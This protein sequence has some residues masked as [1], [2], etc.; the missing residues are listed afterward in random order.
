M[1]GA[2]EIMQR[3]V[4]FQR[5]HRLHHLRGRQPQI[6][7]RH[8]TG[9]AHSLFQTV[10][11]AQTAAH[12]PRHRPAALG[13]TV[14]S[15][16]MKPDLQIDAA[17]GFHGLDAVN[18]RKRGDAFGLGEPTG[19]IGQIGRRRHHH[20]MGGPIVRQRNRHLGRQLTAAVA[21]RACPIGQPREG[22]VRLHH[23]AAAI[24]RD[25]LAWAS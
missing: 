19:E 22:A 12:R 5:R 16:G 9:H 6:R 17:G 3:L 7:G 15:I 4:R 24:R 23:S 13:L 14:G 21:E 10:D 18:F 2:R 8:G 11:A 1:G 20:G 25:R